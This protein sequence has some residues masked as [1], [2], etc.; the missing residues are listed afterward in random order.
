MDHGVHAGGNRIE[1]EELDGVGL[2]VNDVDPALDGRRSGRPS[3][4]APRKTHSEVHEPIAVQVAN[5]DELPLP[6]GEDLLRPPDH[7]K[8]IAFLLLVQAVKVDHGWRRAPSEED[9]DRSP[10]IHHGDA[11]VIEPVAVH[12]AQGPEAHSEAITFY[13]V[14]SFTEA[15]AAQDLR[16]GDLPP[17]LVEVNAGWEVAGAVDEEDDARSHTAERR[18][19]GGGQGQVGL[20]I[21]VE[22]PHI[23]HGPAGHGVLGV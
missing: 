15:H 23:D 19:I 1:V 12:V 22:V 14:G 13:A 6:E 4:P 10:G 3:R 17:H 18:G 2:P 9:E 11:E 21:T 20:A 5:P 8:T 16:P 7:E